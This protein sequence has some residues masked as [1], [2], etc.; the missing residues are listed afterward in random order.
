[1][2]LN[3][4]IYFLKSLHRFVTSPTD[5]GATQTLDNNIGPSALLS[6]E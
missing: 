1:M 2:I 5:L 3:L 4:H 6:Q